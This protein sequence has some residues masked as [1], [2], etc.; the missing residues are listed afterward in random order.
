MK[1]L[2]TPF[3]IINPGNGGDVSP[4]AHEC[5]ISCPNEG[6]G[7]GDYASDLFCPKY[8]ITSCKPIFLPF[9]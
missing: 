5:I 2:D 8:A 9:P 4:M 1:P 7:C 3:E 6:A